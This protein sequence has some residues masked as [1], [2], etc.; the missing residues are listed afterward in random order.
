[1]D[2]C[3]HGISWASSD[4]KKSWFGMSDHKSIIYRKNDMGA[5]EVEIVI[6]LNSPDRIYDIENE[7]YLRIVLC[8]EDDEIM[9]R[10]EKAFDFRK[11]ARLIN[12]DEPQGAPVQ[13]ENPEGEIVTVP[14]DYEE[15]KYLEEYIK[16]PLYTR[17]E[18][19]IDEKNAKQL[20]KILQEKPRY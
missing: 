11:R 1:M 9:Y 12:P 2:I 14:N 15:T 7:R 5:E 19:Y 10:I 4:S 3:Q 20:I 16:Y 6:K 13:I 18:Q 8:P 17:F